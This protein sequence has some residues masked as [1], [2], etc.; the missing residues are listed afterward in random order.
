MLALTAPDI[1]YPAWRLPRLCVRGFW[2][3]F[4]R[5]FGRASHMRISMRQADQSALREVDPQISDEALMARYVAGEQA[6]FA[7]L[8]ARH[9]EPLWRYLTRL[10]QHEAEGE[11]LYQEVWH[12]VIQQRNQFV[13]V[14][15]KP[16]LYRVAR[17]LAID[18]IRRRQLAPMQSMDE[19]VLQFPNAAEQLRSEDSPELAK[20]DEEQHARLLA[21]LAELPAEQRDVVLLKAEGDLT[22]EEMG[23]LTGHGRETVKSRLR[24]ALAK[25]R[26]VLA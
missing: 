25:L 18:V 16:W 12:K 20:L 8:Y 5:G 15:F 7:T 13:D 17:N 10:L 9:R 22:L 2:C 4:G 21:A 23:E 6:A 24:Y 19:M 14:P 1:F 3:G 26:Q 11:E